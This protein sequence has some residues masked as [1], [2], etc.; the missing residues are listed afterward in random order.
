MASVRSQ[1]RTWTLGIFTHPARL[2]FT[3]GYL[4][5]AA[6]AAEHLSTAQEAL[7][8]MGASFIQPLVLPN[9]A[10]LAMQPMQAHA[11]GPILFCLVYP[12]GAL[13][14]FTHPPHAQGG[15]EPTVHFSCSL[16]HAAE[17][18]PADSM[19]RHPRH[20]KARTLLARLLK[21]GNAVAGGAA[22]NVVKLAN[23]MDPTEVSGCSGCVGLVGGFFVCFV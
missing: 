2:P 16:A 4:E 22:A 5:M 19:H 9:P 23:Q 8:L 13:Q 20:G 18:H 10:G 3:S 12:D 21:R 11:G 7:A 15:V 6:A 1:I 17:P 14:I